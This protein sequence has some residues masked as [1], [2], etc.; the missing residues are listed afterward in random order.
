MIKITTKFLTGRPGSPGNPD[1]PFSPGSPYNIKHKGQ[2]H[3]IIYTQDQLHQR[4]NI[5]WP[6]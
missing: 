5:L 4:N 2:Q 1:S 6:Q 3:G